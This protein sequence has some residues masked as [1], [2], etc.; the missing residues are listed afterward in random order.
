MCI[1]YLQVLR[2]E[3]CVLRAWLGML[4]QTTIW[5]RSKIDLMASEDARSLVS[6]ALAQSIALEEEHRKLS[7]DV[8]DRRTI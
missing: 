8:A 2:S 5:R 4:F 7:G 6:R 1:E 3:I